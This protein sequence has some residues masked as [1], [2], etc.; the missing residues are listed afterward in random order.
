MKES[1]A[2]YN[3]AILGIKVYNDFRSC[4]S[5]IEN[6]KDYFEE[7]T[8]LTKTPELYLSHW[9]MSP[10]KARHNCVVKNNE[11]MRVHL[12]N[13]GYKTWQDFEA[14]YNRKKAYLNH[15]KDSGEPLQLSSGDYLFNNRFVCVSF[16]LKQNKSRRLYEDTQCGGFAKQIT[17]SRPNLIVC[18]KCGDYVVDKFPGGAKLYLNS[19]KLPNTLGNDDQLFSKS[20]FTVES[21]DQ[22]IFVD[23]QFQLQIQ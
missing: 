23:P 3:G 17:T 12:F 19:F 6:Y 7:F 13:S 21:D 2:C 1:V 5:I 8:D 4:D 16:D 9:L 22:V 10:G 15:L 11:Y 18:K 20:S 14:D